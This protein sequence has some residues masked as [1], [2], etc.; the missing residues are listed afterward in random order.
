MGGKS[1]LTLQTALLNLIKIL[2]GRKPYDHIQN[3][4]VVAK[5]VVEYFLRPDR[6]D[7]AEPVVLSDDMRA[8]MQIAGTMIRNSG[9]ALKNYLKCSTNW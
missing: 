5:K 8:T 2:C 1:R 4:F 6:P 3:D 9:L 7:D